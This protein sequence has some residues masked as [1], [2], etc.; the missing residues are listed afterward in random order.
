[1]F[2]KVRDLRTFTTAK[3]G[4]ISCAREVYGKAL[5]V[6]VPL[7]C[8]AAAFLL[9][10][11]EDIYSIAMDGEESLKMAQLSKAAER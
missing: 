1:M 10:P 11:V 7:P 8:L 2:T 4:N 6:F 9:F 5:L 3:G